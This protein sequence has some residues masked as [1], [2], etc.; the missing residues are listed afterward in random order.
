M[1]TN[2]PVLMIVTLILSVSLACNAV[3]GA[4]ETPVPT[5]KESPMIQTEAPAKAISTETP[6]AVE[7]S[8]FTE[9]FDADPQWDLA[10]IPDNPDSGE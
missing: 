1:K 7:D 2:R 6:T 5:A 9:E 3:M 4:P 10:V 8:Y